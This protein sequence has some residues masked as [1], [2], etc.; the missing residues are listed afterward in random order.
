MIEDP[1]EYVRELIIDH[2]SLEDATQGELAYIVK[3]T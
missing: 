2:F 3:K 1:R